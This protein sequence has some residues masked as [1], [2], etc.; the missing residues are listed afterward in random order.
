ML[1]KRLRPLQQRGRVTPMKLFAHDFGLVNSKYC[2]HLESELVDQKNL[3]PFS[4]LGRW[5]INEQQQAKPRAAEI[6]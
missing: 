3:S 2:K 6:T 4:L 1:L 5:K